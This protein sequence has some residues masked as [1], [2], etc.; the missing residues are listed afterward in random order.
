MVMAKATLFETLTP[1]FEAGLARV[2]AFKDPQPKDVVRF[3]EPTLLSACKVLGL[4]E[5]FGNMS[6]RALGDTPL[7]NLD[8]DSLRAAIEGLAA[9]AG[10]RDPVADKQAA[11]TAE[12]AGIDDRL[13][14]LAQRSRDSIQ[15]ELFEIRLGSIRGE[16][17]EATGRHARGKGI[18]PMV[19]EKMCR[20]NRE[21]KLQAE[22]DRREAASFEL[23]SN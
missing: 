14:P 5:R 2:R 16:R 18:P 17:D 21:A 3:F 23:V 12:V 15:R 19:W 13:A 7:E 20:G 4:E 9:V 22:L 8:M 1:L 11:L 6:A 10:V